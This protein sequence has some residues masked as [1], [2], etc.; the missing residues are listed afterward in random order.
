MQWNICVVGAGKIGQAIATFLKTSPNYQVT[1]ADHDLNALSAVADLGV[2]T[3]Q[4]DAK[5]PVDLAKGLQGFD[6]VISA[7]PF[8]LTPIT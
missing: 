5:D 8:F 1:L 3:R 6:A 7:A 2:P 4:I